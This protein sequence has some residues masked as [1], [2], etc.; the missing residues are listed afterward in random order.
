MRGEDNLA[1][2]VLVEVVGPTPDCT[3]I[4]RGVVNPSGFHI[5]VG[6][7][8]RVPHKYVDSRRVKPHRGGCAGCLCTQTCYSKTD[9]TCSQYEP[10]YITKR[11]INH[12][13]SSTQ[14]LTFSRAFIT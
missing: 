2:D 7:K 6:S 11:A 9:C 8:I 1:A 12:S 13:S 5:S 4:D 14:S 3:I 10:A